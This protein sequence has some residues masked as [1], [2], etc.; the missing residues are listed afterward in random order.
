MR[1]PTALCATA[2]A[3]SLIAPGVASA[4]ATLGISTGAMRYDDSANTVH[5]QVMVN[6]I[7]GARLGI[8]GTPALTVSAPCTA[9]GTTG[10][11]CPTDSYP[12]AA[13]FLMGSGDDGVIWLTNYQFNSVTAAGAAGDDTIVN[14]DPGPGQANFFNGGPDD[15]KLTAGISGGTSQLIGDSGNDTA[16]LGIANDPLNVSLDG[17]PNDG[18]SGAQTSN[19]DVENVTIY[20]G[21][22]VGNGQD[23]ILKGGDR[24][25]ITGGGGNDTITTGNGAGSVDAGT[26]ND[27]VTTRDGSD[28]VDLGPG[29]DI[30]STGDADDTISALDGAT[31]QI[32]CG[33]GIDAVSADAS[34]VVATSC[35]YIFQR[36][37]S[38]TPSTGDTGQRAAALKKCKKKRHRAAQVAK[39]KCKHKKEVTR[40]IR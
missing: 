14:A 23:N 21:T 3:L 9:S 25:T 30:A 40:L 15:D 17:V 38:A 28:A 22:I 7:D 10:G 29:L 36:W 19:V 4:T 20:R 18:P 6:Q 12:G 11:V 39:K 35:E 1:R 32:D 13:S 8:N 5:N 24:N 33:S 37:P 2:F 31:D 16:S 26:G 34:D 27:E